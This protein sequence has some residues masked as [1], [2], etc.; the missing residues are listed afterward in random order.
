MVLEELSTQAVLALGSKI[1]GPD[2]KDKL[3]KAA[4][5]HSQAPKLKWQHRFRL[6]KLV[7]S[8]DAVDAMLDDSGPGAA[9]LSAMIAGEV[10]KEQE[11]VRSTVLAAILIDVLPE[12]LPTAEARTLAAY[13]LR[14]IGQKIDGVSQQVGEVADD[15]REVGG[16][17]TQANQTLTEL[18]DLVIGREK[19]AA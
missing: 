17:V 18:R 5:S 14:V 6:A 2:T 15:V 9:T 1:A 4:R 16:G 12:C 11:T 7:S 3:L 19:G 13:R 10:F 8:S